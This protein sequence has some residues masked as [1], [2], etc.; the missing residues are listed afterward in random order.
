MKLVKKDLKKNQKLQ[1]KKRDRAGTEKALV[2]A[3]TQLFASKG[4]AATRTLEIAQKAKVNEALIAR[5]FGG[6][7]GLLIAVLQDSD[8]SKQLINAAGEQCPTVNWVPSFDESKDLKAIL[9][10]FFKAGLLHYEEK[11]SFIRIALSQALVDPKMSELLRNK[12]MEQSF[13]S[14]FENLQK[15]F[16]KKIKNS[17]LESLVMLLMASNFSINFMGRMVH[18]I[19]S[20]T[21]DRVIDLLIDSLA[22]HLD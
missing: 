22:A 11:Q 3:A 9:K 13:V 2:K 10:S 12:T 1:P 14:M 15:Y 6:K 21:V 7:E 18:R 5:Y 20:K 19:D 4:F 17:D 16:G 8:A